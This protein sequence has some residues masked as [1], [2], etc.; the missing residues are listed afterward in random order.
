MELGLWMETL[1]TKLW[2]LGDCHG[3]MSNTYSKISIQSFF[4]DESD[5]IFADL[6]SAL[7]SEMT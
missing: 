4:N 6:Y 5:A 3:Y 7:E 2:F 1:P